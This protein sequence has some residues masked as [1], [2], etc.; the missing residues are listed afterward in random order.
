MS[1]E[2]PLKQNAFA[3]LVRHWR[4]DWC[5]GV[6]FVFGVFDNKS[7]AHVGRVTLMLI[8][9]QLQWANLGYQVHQ[10]YR[11]KG[12][13]TEATIA[14]LTFGFEVLQFHRIESATKLDNVAATKVAQRAGMAFEG[15]RRNFFPDRSDSDMSVFAANAIDFANCLKK[16]RGRGAL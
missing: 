3:S 10:R 2:E 12:Y 1:I 6:H 16:G 7:N 9:K 14:L 5:R 11:S 13:A 15:V 8:N 4:N